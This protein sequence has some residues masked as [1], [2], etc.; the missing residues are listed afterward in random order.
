[1]LVITSSLLFVNGKK[2]VKLLERAFFSLHIKSKNKQNNR[3]SPIGGR[4]TRAILNL[5]NSLK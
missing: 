1:M 3:P 5:L 4:K 2:V